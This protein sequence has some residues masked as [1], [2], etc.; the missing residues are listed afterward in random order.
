MDLEYSITETIYRNH[1][2]EIFQI[3]Y[4]FEEIVVVEAASNSSSSITKQSRERRIRTYD[5]TVKYEKY[6][7]FA[8]RL[9]FDAFVNIIRPFIMGFYE[10]DELERAFQTLD[11][12]RSGSIHVDELSSFLPILN[13]AINSDVLI[14]YIQ[15]VDADFDGTMNYDEFRTL[16]LRGIGHDIIFNHI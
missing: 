1:Q 2:R 15:K 3:D 7:N 10:G 14:A 6:A 4:Q 8:N 16:V 13:E 5:I 11:H 9:P 12:D